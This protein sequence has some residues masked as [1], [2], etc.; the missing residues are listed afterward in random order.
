L[1]KNIKEN[2][3]DL[4]NER[5]KLLIKR[6]EAILRKDYSFKDSLYYEMDFIIRE[7]GWIRKF[8][9]GEVDDKVLEYLK[10][11]QNNKAKTKISSKNRRHELFLGWPR[12]PRFTLPGSPYI[13]KDRLEEIRNKIEKFIE[14][15][16]SLKKLYENWNWFKLP[17]FDLD[18]SKLSPYMQLPIIKT[19]QVPQI[20]DDDSSVEE[21]DYEEGIKIDRFMK[22]NNTNIDR[23]TS[24][25][26]EIQEELNNIIWEREGEGGNLAILKL[27]IKE[28]NKKKR[29]IY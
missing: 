8:G 4:F 26:K 11:G 21:E 22:F 28:F 10:E 18:R 20:K 23:I 5:A 16:E 7:L 14:E 15:L 13:I 17:K 25:A 12:L 6:A 2:L 29:K 1:L 24:E 9:I 3:K 19:Y 27:K